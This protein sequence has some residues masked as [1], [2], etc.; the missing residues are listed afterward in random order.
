MMSGPV[1]LSKPQAPDVHPTR[2]RLEPRSSSLGWW[3][4][5]VPQLW[6]TLPLE[7]MAMAIT[8]MDSAPKAAC[9]V[10]P[11]TQRPGWGVIKHSQTMA[12]EAMDHHMISD[13]P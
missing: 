8:D 6:H 4:R 9:E 3:P 7:G 5:T 10:H 12:T 13:F 1:I 2:T 11:E